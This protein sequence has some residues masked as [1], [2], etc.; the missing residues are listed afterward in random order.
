MTRLYLYYTPRYNLERPWMS[1]WNALVELENEGRMVPHCVDGTKWYHLPNVERAKLEAALQLKA[2]VYRRWTYSRLLQ[3]GGD[4]AGALWRQAFARNGWA[5]EHS[6]RLII[7]PLPEEGRHERHEIDVYATKALATHV[8]I[9][10]EVKN[11]TSEGWIDPSIVMRPLNNEMRGVKHHFEAMSA[12]GFTPAL[13]APIIDR[14][15][16]AFQAQHHGLHVQCL[17]HVFD[18]ADADVAQEVKTTFRLGHV[19]P[20]R[21]HRQTFS[22]SSIVSPASFR[23]SDEICSGSTGNAYRT[24]P[25]AQQQTLVVEG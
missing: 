6:A 9:C 3:R 10:A 7:C 22:A 25:S 16:Y 14:S 21:T 11:G 2:N 4:H 19:W 15:F 18:P 5:T 13:F 20:A 8:T 12:L 17:Y 23:P 1:A 24:L